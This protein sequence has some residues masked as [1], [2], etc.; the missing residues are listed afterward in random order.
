V[1]T[2][3][4]KA[5]LVEG[6]GDSAKTEGKGHRNGAG[7]GRAR[8]ADRPRSS[9]R[10]RGSGRARSSEWLALPEP[11]ESPKSSVRKTQAERTRDKRRLAAKL[12]KAEQALEDREREIETL[13]ARVAELEAQQAEK[14]A[15]KAKP[16]PAA[17]PRAA[18]KPRP[19]PKEKP[20][21]K[22][23]KRGNGKRSGAGIN[24]LTFEELRE[25]GLSV[26]QSARLIATRD[27]RGGLE[28]VDD[29][30]K[31]PGFSKSTVAELKRSIE[32]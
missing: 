8:S 7:N 17:K 30:E 16:R 3:D 27:I 29:L 20:Q 1:A 22:A 4:D 26:T 25:H 10:S 12:K 13:R 15:T 5:W 11:G 28:S 6:T 2:Q 21:A 24:E 31:V 14:P 32:G 9:E 23:P 18:A 19:A